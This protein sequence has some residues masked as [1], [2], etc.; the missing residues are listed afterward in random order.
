MGQ[1]SIE[2]ESTKQERAKKVSLLPV[3][4]KH[5]I[6]SLSKLATEIWQQHFTKIIGADQ[7]SY[8]LENFQSPAALAQQLA[9]G[10][11][12]YFAEVAGIRAG[13]LALIPDSK[14]ASLMISKIYV[15]QLNRGLGIGK[16]MLDFAEQ[17]A[18]DLNLSQLWLTVNRHND[19][20]VQWY[21]HQGFQVVDQ[22]KKDIGQGFYMDDYIMQKPIAD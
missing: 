19:S 11:N 17:Y 13:Y 3:T 9:Q 20:T 4:S 2:Q 6:E 14:A 7:V 22:V 12:Y 15:C 5:D 10:V 1:A 8:M 16:T 21:L 18:R